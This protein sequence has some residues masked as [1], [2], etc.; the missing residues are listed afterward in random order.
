MKYESSYSRRDSELELPRNSLRP[1]PMVEIIGK[2]ILWH[3]MKVL[4]Y[5][6]ND[7][8][9]CLGYKGIVKEYANYFLHMSD[10]TFD[11]RE[12]KMSSTTTVSVEGYVAGRR[13]EHH[14]GWTAEARHPIWIA[15]FCFRT[16][17]AFPAVDVD[18][19]WSPMQA[20]GTVGDHD[21]DSAAAAT[22]YWT[23]L[24]ADSAFRSRKGRVGQWRLLYSGARRD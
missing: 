9:V 21:G 19:A 5:G 1:K 20:A 22:G 8:V 24:D 16:A 13:I 2:P 18:A 15:K 6:I 14:D 23:S 17:T 3:I 7:F 10:V 4:T 12:N 11:M